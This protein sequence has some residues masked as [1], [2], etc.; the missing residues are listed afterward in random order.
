MNGSGGFRIH[1]PINKLGLT[2]WTG[3]AALST[4]ISTG[5][6]SGGKGTQGPQGMIGNQGRVGLQGPAGSGGGGS[7]TQGNQGYQGRQGLVGTAGTPG[8][9]G[10]PGTQG[11]QG[12]FS[13]V[14]TSNITMGSPSLSFAS[15]STPLGSLFVNNL[16]GNQA[17]TDGNPNP[18]MYIASN[19]LPSENLKYDFGSPS[20]TWRNAYFGANTI[21]I[22]DVALSQSGTTGAPSLLN[23]QVGGESLQLVN[24][25]ASNNKIPQQLLPF[26]S[27]IYGFS[28]S[29]QNDE[30]QSQ[31][32]N[33]ANQIYSIIN[34]QNPAYNGLDGTPS[35]P[36]G[37]TAL[38]SSFYIDALSGAYYIIQF[39][40]S[41]ASNPTVTLNIP[42]LTFPST[43]NGVTFTFSDIGFGTP[44]N[45]VFKIGDIVLFGMAVN[46]EGTGITCSLNKVLFEVP[47]GSIGSDKI[48]DLAVTHPKIAFGAVQTDNL[49]DGNV[50]F[51]KLNTDVITYIDE[52]AGLSANNDPIAIGIGAGQT[53]QNTRAIAIGYQA[54][55]Y[56]QGAFAIAIGYQAGATAQ[57]SNSII[58]NASGEILNGSTAGFFVSPIRYETGSPHLTLG[59]QGFQGIGGGTGSGIADLQIDPISIGINAGFTG[60]GPQGIAIGYQA[61]NY[62]QGAFSIAIGYQAGFTG[63][64]THSI[65]M[66]ASGQELNAGSTGLF[67]K[68]LRFFSGDP[69]QVGTQGLQGLI[70]VQGVGG[71]QGFQGYQGVQGYLGPQGGVAGLTSEIQFNENDKFGASSNLIYDSLTN[72]FRFG[73]GNTGGQFHIIGGLSQ[74]STGL[75]NNIAQIGSTIL[76][77]RKD[78]RFV[79][80]GTD[81]A[82]NSYVDFHSNENGLIDYDGRILSTGGSTAISGFATMSLYAQNYAFVKSSN[83]ISTNPKVTFEQNFIFASG[84]ILPSAY[85][86]RTR[87]VYEYIMSGQI[88]PNSSTTIMNIPTSDTVTRNMWRL[89]IAISN[90][91]GN[92]NTYNGYAISNTN[93]NNVL[94]IPETFSGISPVIVLGNSGTLPTIAFNNNTGSSANYMILVWTI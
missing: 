92:W 9:P 29:Y 56:D 15:S 43:D 41:T 16:A 21:F 81:S 63:Q 28:I 42:T 79:E 52:Q 25:S 73:Q 49:L 58:I 83:S 77:Y 8:T 46:A 34:E 5:G 93:T 78:G 12:N 72:Q 89:E 32:T 68:P 39:A 26:S 82:F 66:N 31:R 2:T 37:S 50:T 84:N 57:T 55:N 13:G 44:N 47:V 36:V 7:G 65:V 71:F 90:G 61:G 70:G 74:G 94:Y 38:N 80:I 11:P 23:V 48:A 33:W 3:F 6:G 40:G 67:V 4:E 59:L 20:L 64:S 35:L 85:P 87:S 76:G 30:V 60:Q 22:G 75:S 69:V 91:I 45:Q 17:S 18:A 10:T 51:D 19:L 24:T 86:P 54:G 88:N 53:G 62:D 1:T 27:F 14:M